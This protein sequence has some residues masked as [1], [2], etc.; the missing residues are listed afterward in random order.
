[1]EA[2]L[3]LHRLKVMVETA[4]LI[5]VEEVAGHMLIIVVVVVAR[6]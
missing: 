3:A 6:A 4:T 5:Q 1:V 2:V